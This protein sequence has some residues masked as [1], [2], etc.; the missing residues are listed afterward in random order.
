LLQPA[1]FLSTAHKKFRD[2]IYILARV[3]LWGNL[4]P[5]Q[6]LASVLH[7]HIELSKPASPTEIEAAKKICISMD[8]MKFAQLITIKLQCSSIYETFEEGLIIRPKSPE[9]P[10]PVLYS[11]SQN[12]VHNGPIG[13]NVY[14]MNQI[15]NN[16]C[17]IP[18]AGSESPP[19]HPSSPVYN[20]SSPVYN[21]SSPVYNPSSPVY[22]PSSPVY[23]PSP[24][25]N[26][27]SMNTTMNI[28]T[29]NVKESL[30]ES[31]QDFSEV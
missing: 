24:T 19:Y 4:R 5:L 10:P 23:N 29:S 11:P 14:S 27:T 15:A 3:V 31:L 20:P 25:K 2:E 9:E 17:N 7:P 16:Y 22:N 26:N 6:V 18:E 12:T 8:P 21:P 28:S 1:S 30:K 13:S